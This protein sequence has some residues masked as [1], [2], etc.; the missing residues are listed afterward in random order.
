MCATITAR[1]LTGAADTDDQL[2][3]STVR[4]LRVTARDHRRADSARAPRLDLADA[5]DRQLAKLLGVK[6]S[7]L[8]DPPAQE[9][10]S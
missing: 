10:A 7:E 3:E 9:P 8:R 6:K 2:I 5:P 4:V 1:S